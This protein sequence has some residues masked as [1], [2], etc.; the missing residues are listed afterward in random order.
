MFKKKLFRA[1][2]LLMAMAMLFLASACNKEE[3]TGSSQSGIS[4]TAKVVQL[5]VF[6]ASTAS[7]TAA[8]VYDNTWWG[9][10]LKED[11][12]VSLNI[13]PTGDKAAEKLQAL[14]A[15]GALPDIVIFNTTKDVQNAIRGNM[16]VNLDEHLDKLPNVVANAPKALQYYRDNISN[17]TGKL[18][19]V[20]NGV[21]PAD[22]GNE[23]SWGPY[24]R[25]DLYKAAGSPAINT[26]ADYLTA[27]KKMQE[28]QPTNKDGKKTY[29]LTLWKDWDGN[30]MFMATE[31]GPT[32]G[33]DCGDQLGQLPFLQVDFTDNT[34]MN[35][36]DSNSEYMKALKFYYDANQMGLVDPDSLTQTYETAKSKLTEG[37]ILFSWWSWL[38]DA[39]NT[40]ENTNAENAT[41][42]AA[43]LPAD[44]KTLIS[45]ENN[46]GKSWP[47]A[48][49]AATKN[50]D[51]C[52]KYVDYMYSTD[53]LQTLFNGPEGL[54]WTKDASGAPSLT[55]EGWKYVND[56]TLELP[57]GGMLGDGTRTLG[58]Y[59]LSTAFINPATNASVHYQL[60]P[61]TKTY[62]ATNQTKLQKDW[63]S[64]T[65][66]Q[67][68]ID[69]VNGKNM[70]MQIPLAQSL[71]TPMTDETSAAAA[72]IGDIVKTYSWKMIFAKNDAEY[73]SLY[74]EM[75]VKAEGLGE[76]DVFA[77][78]LAGWN[79]A[80]TLAD[81]Y[82]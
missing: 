22:L 19:A 35:T 64:V 30:S 73:T 50:L 81:K 79:K 4:E 44:A 52:L 31:L 80:L 24:L 34:T 11:I 2:S 51:A 16:L 57:D 32:L 8:G 45:G 48:I 42:F 58:I 21:G 39:Y 27:L 37:R 3:G 68:T 41:G 20:A 69:Y 9:K 1:I 36:L 13:L 26:F 61:S 65:G 70:F 40:T 75:I 72:K 15:S 23:T 33:I 74:N 82:K 60:W 10:A 43:V 67:T 47:I 56:P 59:G 17:D 7:T 63:A 14:M 46:I 18:Y 55:T 54:T 49:S 28:L 53:G 38:N 76:K 62:N 5:D 25:W 6:S 12:G 71:I 29:G 77:T 66:Y 78:S